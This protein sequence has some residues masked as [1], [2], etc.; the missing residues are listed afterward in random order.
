MK[1]RVKLKAN[2]YYYP[3]YKGWLWWR[4]FTELEYEYKVRLYYI[5]E[6]RAVA[7]IK[8]HC[9]ELLI[10]KDLKLVSQQ[11]TPKEVTCSN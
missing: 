3:Q 4:N 8:N 10:K 7:Y 1:Y 2:G 6:E 11:Y 9:R 5:T